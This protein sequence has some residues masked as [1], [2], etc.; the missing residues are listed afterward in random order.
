MRQE[1]LGTIDLAEPIM[2]GKAKFWRSKD[3]SPESILEAAEIIHKKTDFYALVSGGKDA[4][5]IAHWLSEQNRLK[6]VLHIDT[7]VGIQAT[8]DF[9]KDLC[10]DQG[11]PLEILKPKPPYVYASMALEFGF[12]G[13]ANHSQIMGRLKSET[14]RHYVKG[15]PYHCMITGV[16]KFE[17]ARRQGK[18][19]APLNLKNN[20]FFCNPFFYMTTEYTY[21]YIHEHGLKITPVHAVMGMSGECN[22][23][24]FGTRREKELITQL[25]PK[26]A[27]YISWLE[28][29]IKKFGTPMAKKYGIWG[30]NTQRIADIKTGQST[31]DFDAELCGVECGPG[32]LRGDTDFDTPL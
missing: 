26:L 13:P 6:A 10:Q 8:Q 5:S 32:T 17:S 22:C 7:G 20:V 9:V 15:K 16:R 2:R 25:D 14:L 23:G 12:P 27:D 11:W 1:A 21:R 30:G 18:Y 4:V 31:L 19:P 24:S 3:E 29:G 28:E